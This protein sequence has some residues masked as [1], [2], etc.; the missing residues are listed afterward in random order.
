MKIKHKDFEFE[1]SVEEFE[2][3]QKIYPMKIGINPSKSRLLSLLHL[4][5][6]LGGDKEF[7]SVRLIQANWPNVVD[8]PRIRQQLYDRSG[9]S[10]SVTKI[11]DVE[12]KGKKA[13]YRLNNE[14]LE[15]IGV[16]RIELYGTS[17]PRL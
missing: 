4:I 9:S 13:K 14:G 10:N 12:G 1:G 6:K 11:F 15:L 17:F 16:K 3:F 8:W 5:Q 2:Q 7:I